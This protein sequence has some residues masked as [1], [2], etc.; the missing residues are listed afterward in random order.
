MATHE[1]FWRVVRRIPR[2]RVSTY[3]TVARAAGV[4][5]A[6]RQVGYA[7]AALPDGTDVPWQRV[8][9][10]RGEVSPRRL[11]GPDLL[12]RKLLEAE[13]VRFDARGRVDL[14][15]YGWRPGSRARAP[16]SAPAKPRRGS[17]S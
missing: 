11:P 4:P 12:Q 8:V 9:N 6:A 3:G 7:L 17:R 13:G 10:A 1:R 2:G 14:T 16:R 5:G 15:R